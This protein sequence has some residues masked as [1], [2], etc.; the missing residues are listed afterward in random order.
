VLVLA[1]ALALAGF[2]AGVCAGTGPKNVVFLA[3]RDT[4][5][6]KKLVERL[7]QGVRDDLIWMES[8]AIVARDARGRLEVKEQWEREP[9]KALPPGFGAGLTGM[10]AVL[11]GVVGLFFERGEN[12]GLGYITGNAAARPKKPD[13]PGAPS[14]WPEEFDD[15]VS[16][17]ARGVQPGQ[18][19]LIAVIE[20][21]LPPT[22]VVV[23]FDKLRARQQL[24]R[25]IPVLK[26]VR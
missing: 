8:Y 26:T 22:G 16:R 14:V 10:A 18:A 20:E 19:A 2:P 4:A 12:A 5:D 24:E 25:E 13:W 3:A 11:G 7:E 21:R 1:A 15:D 17:L 9:P 6:A 23:D